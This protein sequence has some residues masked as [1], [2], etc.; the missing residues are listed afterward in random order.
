MVKLNKIVIAWVIISTLILAVIIQVI[1]YGPGNNLPDKLTTTDQGKQ[2]TTFSET[3]LSAIQ[4]GDLAELSK[5]YSRNFNNKEANDLV[6]SAIRFHQP[7]QSPDSIQLIRLNISSIQDNDSK[8]TIIKEA[9]I[10]YQFKSNWYLENLAYA[11]RGNAMQ[12]LNYSFNKLPNSLQK[13]NEVVLSETSVLQYFALATTIMIFMI[14]IFALFK[15]IIATNLK[16]KWLWIIFILVGF[17]QFNFNW[18]TQAFT[19]NPLFFQVLGAGFYRASRY[20]PL[21]LSF[22]IPLGAIMFLIKSLYSRIRAHNTC[23]SIT[24]HINSK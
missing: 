3:L 10:Q 24:K 7:T 13:I 9:T 16:R 22:S 4:R 19:I 1:S 12:L 6:S 21:M 17:F 14:I 2:V 18:T 15:C 5:Y 23:Q 20:T 8:E 11:Q